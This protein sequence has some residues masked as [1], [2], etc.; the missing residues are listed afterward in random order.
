MIYNWAYYLLACEN[1][2]FSCKELAS[3]GESAVFAYL[4]TCYL[5]FFNSRKFIVNS[6]FYSIWST[7]HTVRIQ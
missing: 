7:I 5:F 4:Q 3:I 2:R 1:S 6:T